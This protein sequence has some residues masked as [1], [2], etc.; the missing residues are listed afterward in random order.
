MI[1]YL[2]QFDILG[3]NTIF[4]H[5]V[6]ISKDEIQLLKESGTSVSHNPVSN[7]MLADGVAPVCEML[8]EGVNVS[9]GTD[10]AAS[11]HS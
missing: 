10:G 5:C 7:M 9:L 11:N 1:K 6:H 2:E 4:A 8:A 3:E